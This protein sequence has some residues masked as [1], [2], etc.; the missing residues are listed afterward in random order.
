MRTVVLGP[1]TLPEARGTV[2][3]LNRRA[4]ARLGAGAQRLDAFARQLV[5]DAGQGVAPATLAQRL[6]T[7]AVRDALDV[8]D[9]GL[10]AR[11]LG[12]PL[13]ELL[14][15]VGLPSETETG[16]W[17]PE[18]PRYLCPL[19]VAA[20]GK[21]RPPPPLREW[22]RPGRRWRN[23]PPGRHGPGAPHLHTP[24]TCPRPATNDT[25]VHLA[26][27]SSA[28]T[29]IYWG[30]AVSLYPEPC[31][32]E[33]HE[34][35]TGCGTLLIPSASSDSQEKR[36]LL[37]EHSRMAAGS[38]LPGP[39]ASW[40]VFHSMFENSPLLVKFEDPTQQVRWS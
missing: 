33:N 3:T 21:V 13:R 11:S 25:F 7:G 38:R 5:L 36:T 15:G 2:L 39:A 30:A 8:P 12:G 22:L 32:S 28:G 24:A 14:R 23:R 17:R 4:A 1:A 35:L 18:R 27:Q 19:G 10:V 31:C 37:S 20:M 40:Q 34:R 16:R 26:R 6:L 9:P 29:G